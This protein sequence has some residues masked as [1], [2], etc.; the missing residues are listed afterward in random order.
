MKICGLQLGYNG[1]NCKNQTKIPRLCFHGVIS[2]ILR[3]KLWN[4]SLILL[5]L[6]LRVLEWIKVMTTNLLKSITM[7]S[8]TRE[9]YWF[10]I[11]PCGFLGVVKNMVKTIMYLNYWKTRNGHQKESWNIVFWLFDLFL[12][13]YLQVDIASS[14]LM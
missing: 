8:S 4:D 14:C 5:W 3:Y 12:F 1:V 9:P 11:F 13:S 10:F 2:K 6:H 7:S